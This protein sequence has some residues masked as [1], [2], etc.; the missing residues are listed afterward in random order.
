ML[1]RAAFSDYSR[2]VRNQSVP[3]SDCRRRRWHHASPHIA[4]SEV[5]RFVCFSCIASRVSRFFVSKPGAKVFAG[6]F[7]EGVFSLVVPTKAVFLQSSAKIF[8]M[9]DRASNISALQT[10]VHR[11]ATLDSRNLLIIA[12]DLHI[13]NHSG[14]HLKKT[15]VRSQVTGCQAMR[16]SAVLEISPRRRSRDLS[17][18]T[19]D[20]LSCS[21]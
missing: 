19:C 11:Q 3:V 13:V 21:N 16:P 6:H 10:T 15:G 4:G 8:P 17:S 1:S 5:L 7:S 9:P 18:T 14:K 12:S 20:L 2:P